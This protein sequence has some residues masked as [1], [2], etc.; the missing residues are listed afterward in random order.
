MPRP[1]LQQ[2]MKNYLR[3]LRYA[4]PYRRLIVLATI[5]NV[6]MVLFS[7]ASITVLIPILKIIF[8]NTC[9]GHN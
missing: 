6:L 1:E 3:I 7:L 5:F 2:F 8:Q 9:W 4:G